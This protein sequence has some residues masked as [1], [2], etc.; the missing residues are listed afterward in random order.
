ML[1]MHK[2][3]LS[4]TQGPEDKRVDFFFKYKVNIKF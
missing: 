1:L 4:V 2:E 3:L